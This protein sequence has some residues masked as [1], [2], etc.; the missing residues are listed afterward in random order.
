MLIKFDPLRHASVSI[1]YNDIEK[2]D[3]IKKDISIFIFEKGTILING[4]TNYR[5]LVK[6]YKF[7]MVFIL[8]NK[9]KIELINRITY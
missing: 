3:K 5:D 4:S 1:K 7:I 9:E 6:A 8:R 2:T